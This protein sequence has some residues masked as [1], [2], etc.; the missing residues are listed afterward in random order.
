MLLETFVP[1]SEVE[2]EQKQWDDA[3]KVLDKI[4]P[5][6]RAR[7]GTMLSQAPRG[8]APKNEAT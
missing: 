8:E 3:L 6:A 2:A 1:A 7:F 5:E 4:N